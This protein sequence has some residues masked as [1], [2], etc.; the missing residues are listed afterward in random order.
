ML[1][2]NFIT[3]LCLFLMYVNILYFYQINKFIS[4]TNIII[5][6]VFYRDIKLQIYNLYVIIKDLIII[7]TYLI[8]M[9]CLIG[10]I[11]L[12]KFLCFDK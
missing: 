1:I 2:G 5:F 8:I 12:V 7:Y 6:C 3:N 9:I 4:I 10:S 11:G